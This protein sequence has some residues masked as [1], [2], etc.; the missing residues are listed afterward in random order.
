MSLLWI[1]REHH[2]LL[3]LALHLVSSLSLIYFRKNKLSYI[4]EIL[5]LAAA[6][7]YHTPTF[8]LEVAACYIIEYLL[9]KILLVLIVYLAK[10]FA[11]YIM[12]VISHKNKYNLLYKFLIKKKRFIRFQSRIWNR[13][14][15]GIRIKK[16]MPSMVNKRNSRTGISFDKDG[17][18]KFKPIAEVKIERKYWRKDREAHFYR[19]SKILYEQI[20][21][22]SRLKKKFSQRAIST[23]KRGDLPSK[24]SWHHH[25]DRG[26]MQ[27]VDSEIHSK[28][29]HN[30]G[31][32]IWGKKESK[33]R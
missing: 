25:Q 33:N 29:R 12:V 9:A 5:L 22:S 17:F 14:D 23:F 11:F 4:T 16:G 24:Y 26:V 8:S 20:Q 21:K 15:Y 3:L 30:G 18:P 31:Y 27:L 6:Y 7:W 13:I 10:R 19:A 32:S 2:L 28:V 1:V